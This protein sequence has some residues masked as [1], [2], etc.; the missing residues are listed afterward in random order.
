MLLVLA[1]LAWS[2]LIGQRAKRLGLR[3][4]LQLLAGIL[5]AVA[6]QYFFLGPS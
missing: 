3:E 5:V 4:Q 2:A 6:V 1:V